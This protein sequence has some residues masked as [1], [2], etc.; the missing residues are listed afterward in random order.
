ALWRCVRD[1][2]SQSR[3]RREQSDH[4]GFGRPPAI[5]GRCRL[6]ADEGT[7]LRMTNDK[8]RMPKELRNPKHEEPASRR[9]IRFSEFRV[10][11]LIRH[12]DFVIRHLRSASPLGTVLAVVLLLS[13]STFVKVAAKESPGNLLS[14]GFQL[15]SAVEKDPTLHLRG[16]DARQQLLVTAKFDSGAL[17]DF[18]RRVGYSVSP[19]NVIKIDKAG[20]V[21]PLS[22]G[23]AI[24][25]AK[26]P[27][28][29]SATLPVVVEHFNEVA[30]VNFPNQIV[31]IFTKTGCN[32][33]GCH[34]KS[35]G[36]NGFRLS[37]LGFE[38]AEDYEHLVKEPRCRRL[39]PASPENSLLL[40]NAPATL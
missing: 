34:G 5:S 28:G 2:L 4:Y 23:S 29:L 17:G 30:P 11:S 3:H 21:T 10:S 31:P 33:G 7:G 6:S 20:R 27:D 32:G 9:K 38:P 24:I 40:L 22:D 1:A 39:F 15:P 14:L 13:V 26:G 8:N 37:L 16:Q 25:M 36:Q 19:A 35:S 12:S 18:T